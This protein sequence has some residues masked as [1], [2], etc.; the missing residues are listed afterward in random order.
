MRACQSPAEPAL[1]CHRQSSTTRQMSCHQN[2]RISRTSRQP[3]FPTA[4]AKGFE[5]PFLSQQNQQKESRIAAMC[6]FGPPKLAGALGWWYFFCNQAQKAGAQAKEMNQYLFF[7]CLPL[8]HTQ[9]ASQR[10]AISERKAQIVETGG[11]IPPLPPPLPFPQPR[12]TSKR[13][14][15]ISLRPL[16]PPSILM[17]A[18]FQNSSGYDCPGWLQYPYGTGLLHP[19]F[20]LHGGQQR[21]PVR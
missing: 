12:F 14:P 2:Q 3:M 5:A 9:N 21:E 6:L 18:Q 7:G 16:P 1:W 4:T 19:F 20:L 8:S 13:P 15:Q 11:Q 17:S 10:N